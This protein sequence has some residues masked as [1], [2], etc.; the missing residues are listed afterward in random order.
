MC[1]QTHFIV[2][3]ALMSFKLWETMCT[4]VFIDCQN[5]E[6]VDLSNHTGL[7]RRKDVG[8]DGCRW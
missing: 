2:K 3:L 5:Q 4:W 8:Y 6:M 1:A 7:Q